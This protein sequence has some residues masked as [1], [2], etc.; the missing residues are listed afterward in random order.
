MEETVKSV[1]KLWIT[2]LEEAGDQCRVRTQRDA[3]YATS[4][5][6]DEGLSFLT[7][8]LPNFEKDFLVA[9]SQ[10]QV[11]SSHF[12]GFRRSGGLP[13]FLSGFLRQIFD[14]KGLLRSD[15]S[16]DV[17]RSLRQVL[18]L[19]SKIELPT[20]NSREIEALR[21]Y[22]ET[23]AEL[24]ECKEDDLSIFSAV[25]RNLLSPF[26][27]AV[28]ARLWLGDWQP[29][30]SSGAVATRESYNSRFS[31]IT[32]TERLERVFPLA[33][34]LV[35]SPRELLDRMDEISVLA[36]HD[37]PPVRVTVVPKTMKAPRIIAMEPSWMQYVQQ[38]ILNVM[39]ETLQDPYFAKLA[40]YFSWLDQEPNRVLAREGSKDGDYA[41]LDLSEA[42]DRVSL[43]LAE[44]LLECSPFL[45]EC[46]LAC[47]S[48]RAD[49]PLDGG[50]VITLNKF[51][52]M[53]SA[54]CF[55]I[56]S[57]VFFVIE[58][59]AFAEASGIDP[60]RIRLRDL[61]RMRVF[62]DDLIVPSTV[63]RF[64]IRRLEDFG[65]KVNTRKSFT[66]GYFRESCG[67]DW[68][69]GNDVSVFKLRKPLPESRHQLEE[70]ERGIA[71]H[72]RVY[73]AGWF[74]LAKMVEDC[75]FE[76]IP[77]IPR[78]PIHTPISA[79]WTHGDDY[80]VRHHPSYHRRMLKQLR[81]RTQKPLDPLDGYGALRKFYSPHD[82]PREVNHLQRD[83]R[84][85]RVGMNVEWVVEP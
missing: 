12:A 27:S 84:S 55:P 3:A 66:T 56:E 71:F 5:I 85:R 29:R 42:S 65:L 57:M 46:I 74:K 39:T 16:P 54:M 69:Q 7:I 35:T 18:L 32:W 24:I 70:I 34:D 81:F 21:A 37:E 4:R 83:G 11:D 31:F 79:L 28:S 47:R 61:P 15:A 13:K 6:K 25:S 58:A 41:T 36:R 48:E 2:C 60:L 64:L 33:E 77:R 51:A 8:T 62:G 72:N 38:G 67:S 20:T 9:L 40:G 30:H 44:S 53:G 52:S 14:S 50:T 10:G 63:A 49:V 78:A 19:C 76:V 68:Y 26:F 23:D 43:E 73:D 1:V 82:E 75:L 22:I 45:K 80:E 17:I 59:I